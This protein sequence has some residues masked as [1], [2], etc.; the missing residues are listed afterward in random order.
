MPEDVGGDWIILRMASSKTLPLTKSLAADGFRVWTPIEPVT[1]AIRRSNASR[2]GQR[3]IMPS[4][5]FVGREHRDDMLRLIAM[6]DKPRRGPGGRLPAHADFRIMLYAG[7]I[8]VISDRALGPLRVLEA[9]RAPKPG[10]FAKGV[11]VK[12]SNDIANGSFGGLVG[13][14]EESDSG[15]TLV[16][17]GPFFTDV[18]IKTSL[19]S[20]EDL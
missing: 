14:V 3:A 19:L 10:A 20:A 9:R 15:I 11:K 1:I 6:P 12:V 18:K 4:Y 17:F 13:R 7:K 8:P 16:C 5:V 2:T